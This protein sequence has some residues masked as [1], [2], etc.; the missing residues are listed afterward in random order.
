MK[1]SPAAL[2]ALLLSVAAAAAQQTVVV[3]WNHTWAAMHPMGAMPDVP[4]GGDAD[5]DTTWFLKAADFAAQYDGPQFGGAQ[6]GNPATANSF[7]SRLSQ[8]PFGYDVI[9][10]FA[11][12][13]EM[14]GFG[15]ND[16]D[17]TNGRAAQL[18]TPAGTAPN[19]NRRAAYFRT[20]FTVPAGASLIRPKFRYLIDDGAYVYLDGVL[21][22]AINMANTT[23]ANRDTYAGTPE[24]F[25]AASASETLLRDLDLTLPAGTVVAAGNGRI[26]QTVSAIAEGEHTLAVSARNNS[27]TSSDMC[28]ALELSGDTGCLISATTAN[29]T[30]DD[31]GTALVPGDDTFSFSATVTGANAGPGWTSDDPAVS[32]G[33]YDAATSFGPYPVSGG[34][35]T[36][37]F[38]AAAVATCTAQ[39]TVPPPGGTLSAAAQSWTRHPQGTLDPADDTFTAGVLVSGQFVT[40]AWKLVSV[41]PAAAV[42]FTPITGTTGAVTVFGPFAVS[43]SPVTV[44]LQDAADASITAQVVLTPQTYIGSRTIAG[45]TSQF[46]SAA[47]LPSQWVATTALNPVITMSNAGGDIWRE[48]RSPVFDLTST[49][50]LGFFMELVARDTSTTSNFEDPDAFRAKLIVTDA[51]GTSEVNLIAPFDTDGNGMLNGSPTPYDAAADEFNIKREAVAISISNTLRL[52]AGIPAGA[53]SVQ[54]VVEAKSIATNEFFDVRRISFSDQCGFTATA[55]NVTRNLHGQSGNPAAH[56][57]E[58]TLRA[59]PN[60]AVSGAGWDVSFN[61]LGV[62]VPGASVTGGLY[63]SN[64]TVTG[65][66]AEGGPITAILKDRSDANCLTGLSITPPAAPLIIGTLI[67]GAASQPVYSNGPATGWT[68]LAGGTELTNVTAVSDFSTL[69][70]DLSAFAG[71]VQ[72][73]MTL[74][75]EET[76]ATSN[77]EDTDIFLAELILSDGTNTTTVNLITPFDDNALGTMNGGPATYDAA[78]DEFNTAAEAV[79][80][81][82]RNSFALSHVIPDNI[83]SA[84]LHVR[85]QVNGSEFLRMLNVRWVAPVPPGNA[86][87]DGDGMSDAQEAL[88]GTSPNDAASVFRVTSFSGNGF[89]L[90]AGFSTVGGK[91]YQGYTSADLTT[92]TRDDS[93]AAVAGDGN[94]GSWPFLISAGTPVKYYRVAVGASAGGFPASL[95]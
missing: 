47:P 17:S 90:T 9:T 24:V 89:A 88:A 55:T 49:G 14:T 94:A 6:N 23:P 84:T 79:T 53:N 48:F 27:L 54:L 29:V 63:S 76:S 86:D 33:A 40:N 43:S 21:I 37:T 69:P 51:A 18:T 73:S 31:R 82:L 45:V 81:S 12:G 65:L 32:A 30:R 19:T 38:T 87:S 56:T 74:E 3:P 46:L 2:A 52:E 58:F 41:T 28:M 1:L 85:G 13:A 75:A 93:R 39:V 62:P 59:I 92:W 42:P 57:V 78:L 7:D 68:A 22:A 61:R 20:T 10:Y 83:V 25:A 44:V 80:V 64:V 77:F 60:G 95:P 26:V 35:K 15:D 91:F 34:A 36:L 11:P 4:P 70:V 8:G 16:G 5:F 50:A 72:F 67:S 71:D 66:P